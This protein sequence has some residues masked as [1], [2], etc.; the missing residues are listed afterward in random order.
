MA[1]TLLEAQKH[2]RTPQELAVVTELAAGPLLQ[3]LPFR[4]I[5]GNGLFWKREEALPDV[6][7]RN[8]NGA[9]AESYAEVSQQSESLKLFG[10]DIK[11]DRAIVDLEGAQ[12][13]AYQIQSRVRAM[14]LA[15]EALFIKGDS[16]QSPSEFDGLAAR[17]KS[18][19]SQYFQNG[20][21]GNQAL[22]LGTLDEAIDAVDAQG[23]QKYLVMSKSARR[24]L[25]RQARTNTQIDIVRN[26][27]GYQQM[28][29]AGLPV[30]EL[31]RDHK[32]VAILDATPTSQ[33]L[34]VVSFGNDHLTGIQNGGVSVRELGESHS[35][36]QLITRVEW[37]CGL[38]L[39]NGRA[40][41]RVADFNSN[42]DPS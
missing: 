37:Y 25:S 32:N 21:A 9:L 13:K 10:G 31:D 2:A 19:S 42:L 17:I 22:N 16:N 11:V 29:Y 20:T 30:L 35:Q 8:Y 12:A 33:D 24:A 4:N 39:I 36:P 5:E 23:G 28:I 1:L 14:R 15:W 26:E 41:A 27:F 6:G 7:F 38:A 18:G 3:T 40:A 34:Y